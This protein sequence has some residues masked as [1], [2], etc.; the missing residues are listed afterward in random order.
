MT[1]ITSGSIGRTKSNH[2]S[3]VTPFGIQAQFEDQIEDYLR[4]LEE[5]EKTLRTL[6]PVGSMMR[7]RLASSCAPPFQILTPELLRDGEAGKTDVS[8]L[9]LHRHFISFQ[10]STRTLLY[11]AIEKRFILDGHSVPS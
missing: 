11:M 5:I 2:I 6:K 8:W 7:S 1:R 3:I 9:S 10:N 4:D